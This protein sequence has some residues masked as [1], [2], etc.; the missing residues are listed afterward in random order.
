VIDRWIIG[1]ILKP[2]DKKP[3]TSLIRF[4]LLKVKRTRS[5]PI[6]D[7]VVYD[8]KFD[9]REYYL[10]AAVTEK[11]AKTHIKKEKRGKI[12]FNAINDPIF[13]FPDPITAPTRKIKIANNLYKD[14]ETNLYQ[15]PT[16]RGVSCRINHENIDMIYEL[17]MRLLK[18]AQELIKKRPK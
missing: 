14:P 18:K 3:E 2:R 10:A 7:K 15:F 12:E 9:I 8:Y 17:L 1:S 5:N 4:D 6:T 16:S 11:E 13:F